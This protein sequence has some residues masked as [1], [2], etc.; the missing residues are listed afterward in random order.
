MNAH[1]MIDL[2][3]EREKRRQQDVIVHVSRRMML[4]HGHLGNCID[5]AERERAHPEIIT[6]LKALVDAGSTLSS[7]WGN[8]LVNADPAMTNFVESLRSFGIF[9]LAVPFMKPSPMKTKNVLVSTALV[10]GTVP[11]YSTKPLGSESLTGITM[12]ETKVAAMVVASDEL[13]RFSALGTR[14]LGS[15][16]RRCVAVQTDTAFLQ[17]ISAGISPVASSGA[18]AANIM[19]DIDAAA[20]TMTISADA[21]LFAVTTPAIARAIRTKGQVT[22]GGFAFPG[23]ISGDPFGPYTL[24]A[25]DGV[26][27]GQMII[28]DAAQL[29]ADPGSVETGQSNQA[30]LEMSDTPGSPPIASTVVISLWQ[31]NLSALRA[32]RI[33]A[34]ERPRTTS[35]GIIQTIT[36]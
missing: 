27:S 11:E 2:V 9:D 18:T 13:L 32:E 6:I 20:D 22:N 31:N 7:T 8:Q 21:K 19:T 17:K 10:G 25:S 28:F 35:V 15:E 12:S 23:A 33:F 14:L 36:Y 34:V 29:C 4:A 3:A 5:T 30:T 1:A 26:P 24:V 16:I